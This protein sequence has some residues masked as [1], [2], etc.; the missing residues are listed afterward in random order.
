MITIFFQD[1]NH[2]S[3][4]NYDD[5]IEHLQFH[6]LQCPCGKSGCLIR[7]G[8]YRRKVK[9]LSVSVSLLI[10]RVRCKECR[11]T[12]ALIPSLLVPYSQ[13]P[14]KDQQEIL[15]CMQRRQSPEEVLQRNLLIDENN[16]KY[17][18]RQFRRFWQQRL[19]SI[20]ASLSDALTVPCLSAYAMQF[21]QIRRTRNLLFVPPT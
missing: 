12:S 18:F 20:G 14:L 2:F 16:V 10:Q 8:H 5:T 6:M 4:K 13:I 9:F 11:Q 3:Q 17:M 15:A 7:Y 21:M 1:C 19:L